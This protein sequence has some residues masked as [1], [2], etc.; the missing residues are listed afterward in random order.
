MAAKSFIKY[1]FIIFVKIEG[2]SRREVTSLQGLGALGRLER[3][4][5]SGRHRRTDF[6]CGL[7]IN[8]MAELRRRQE[9]EEG[10]LGPRFKGTAH[11]GLTSISQEWVESS[12]LLLLAQV[13]LGGGA[14][15]FV[16]TNTEECSQPS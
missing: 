8:P 10:K 2:I 14:A 5:R 9:V 4:W 11:I 15:L 12:L 1:S 3:R 6:G 13:A 7:G 16:L